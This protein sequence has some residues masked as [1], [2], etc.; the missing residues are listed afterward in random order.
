MTRDN[1]YLPSIYG[2]LIHP[3]AEI[4]LSFP[5]VDKLCEVLLNWQ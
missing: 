2:T 5:F 4:N 1:G 3:L